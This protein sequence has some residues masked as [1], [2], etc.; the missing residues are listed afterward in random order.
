MKARAL[1]CAILLFTAPASAQTYDVVLGGKALGQL[2]YVQKGRTSTLRSTLDNTPLGVFNGS[3]SGTSTG[4]QSNSIFTGESRSSRKQRDVVVEISDGRAIRTD[5]TPANEYTDVSDVARV[6]AGVMDPVRAIGHLIDAQ[7]CPAPVRL[8]DGRRVVTLGTT[9]QELAGTALFCTL[10]YKVI[11]G[12]GHLSPLR[13]SSARMMLS[14]DVAGG[15]QALKQ[16]KISSG[17]FSL[18]LDLQE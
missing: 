13:I 15:A 6:P 9:A 5:I 11:A 3:F 14:Y 18:R 17:I 7:G 4:T 12:P 8:Y 2:S 1:I 16:M 10:H